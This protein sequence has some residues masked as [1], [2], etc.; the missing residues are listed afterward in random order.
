MLP[1]L[2]LPKRYGTEGWKGVGV[3][4]NAFAEAEAVDDGGGVVE[5]RGI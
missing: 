5:K 1:P 3:S 2:R 4:E